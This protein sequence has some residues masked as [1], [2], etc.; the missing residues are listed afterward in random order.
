[1]AP[2]PL[3]RSPAGGSSVLL[4]KNGPKASDKHSVSEPH[5]PEL[6]SLVAV[7]RLREATETSRRWESVMRWAGLSRAGPSRP[8]LWVQ[9]CLPPERCSLL[10]Q[11]ARPTGRLLGWAGQGCW[12]LLTPRGAVLGGHETHGIGGEVTGESW[13]PGKDWGQRAGVKLALTLGRG[14]WYPWGQLHGAELGDLVF[15]LAQEPVSLCT[16]PEFTCTGL[17]PLLCDT[18]G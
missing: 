14:V 3:P 7:S 5:R 15:V 10:R 2:S 8:S 4:Q 11:P 16:R 9:P 6:A 12:A 13:S 1:M 18:P 17:R